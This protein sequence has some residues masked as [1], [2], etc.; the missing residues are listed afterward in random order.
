MT[1]FCIDIRLH[2]HWQLTVQFDS[3]RRKKN[4]EMNEGDED[5]EEKNA[6]VFTSAKKKKKRDEHFSSHLLYISLYP[7]LAIVVQ[8]YSLSMLLPHISS[9]VDIVDLLFFV[10]A[11]DTESSAK[12]T[13]RGETN[14]FSFSPLLLP[15][16]SIFVSYLGV[17]N[18]RIVCFFP[19]ISSERGRRRKKTLRD[20]ECA[21]IAKRGEKKERNQRKNDT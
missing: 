7:S 21:R 10:C 9:S 18:T 3:H 17:L 11:R 20:D 5:E 19:H 13:D 14:H 16:R 4:N 6:L 2:D 8:F 15:S 1:K 12:K